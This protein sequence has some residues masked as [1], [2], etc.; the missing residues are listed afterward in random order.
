MLKLALI[1]AER[2][3]HCVA[4]VLTASIGVNRPIAE[5]HYQHGYAA[6][7]QRLEFFSETRFYALV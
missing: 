3:K 7:H 6:G 1:T 5:D 4:A 2:F